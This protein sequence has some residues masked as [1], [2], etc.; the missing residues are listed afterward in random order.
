[1][2]ISRARVCATAAAKGHAEEAEALRAVLKASELARETAARELE[3]MRA[4]AD[5]HAAGGIFHDQ[6]AFKAL[7][8]S[9]LSSEISPTGDMLIVT[10]ALEAVATA[11]M[12]TN[13]I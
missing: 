12:T 8:P 2:T 9:D 4:A 3:M 6:E 7:L 13:Q 1:M 10:A 11:D 5:R